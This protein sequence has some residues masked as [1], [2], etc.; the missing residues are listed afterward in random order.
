MCVLFTNSSCLL[1]LSTDVGGA[2]YIHW[3]QETCDAEGAEILHKGILASTDR[4]RGGAANIICLTSNLQ[5][6][7]TAKNFKRHHRSVK[8]KSFKSYFVDF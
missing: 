5:N 7:D 6:D 2:T 4:V 3:G 8:L 1:A